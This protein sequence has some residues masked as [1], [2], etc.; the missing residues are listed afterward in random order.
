MSMLMGA[1]RNT[2]SGFESKNTIL[3]F[4]MINININLFLRFRLLEF[5]KFYIVNPEKS[6]EDINSTMMCVCFFVVFS[7]LFTQ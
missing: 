1:L 3:F 6:E 7:G 2:Y 5:Q 4:V